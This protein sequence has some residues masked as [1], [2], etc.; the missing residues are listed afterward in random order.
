M[1]TIS[2]SDISKENMESFNSYAEY[3]DGTCLT[4]LDIE[5]HFCDFFR[6]TIECRDKKLETRILLPRRS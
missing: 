6:D 3:R 1:R 2:K 5:A 4:N